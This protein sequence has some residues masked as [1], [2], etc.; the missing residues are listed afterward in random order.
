MVDP[1]SLRLAL[2]L[3]AGLGLAGC[4]GPLNFPVDRGYATDR[5]W[6]TVSDSGAQDAF[7]PRPD[8]QA[9]DV[10]PAP[11]VGT[12]GGVG[13][14]CPCAP[15]LLC[16]S[17]ICRK[18]C[19]RTGICM[20]SAAECPASQSCAP[21]DKGVGACVPAVGAGQPC[22]TTEFC[23]KDFACAAVSGTQH[24]CQ[25]VCSTVG[26]GCGSGGTCLATGSA[27]CAVCS[28]L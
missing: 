8:V 14:P 20:A 22:S 4:P 11:D 21:T 9:G 7:V 13:D 25:P 18:P 24:T 19:N 1:R 16:A 10:G 3:A 27:T 28:S 12:G 15:P 23:P 6:P 17:G 2:V 5:S 26:A